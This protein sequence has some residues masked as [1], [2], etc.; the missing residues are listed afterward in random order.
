MHPLKRHSECLWLICHSRVCV[1]FSFNNI[2]WPSLKEEDY[3]AKDYVKPKKKHAAVCTPNSFQFVCLNQFEILT[4]IFTETFYLWCGVILYL[5]LHLHFLFKSH[6]QG[7]QW[8]TNLPLWHIILLY[9]HLHCCSNPKATHL[10][11]MVCGNLS[12]SALLHL[13]QICSFTVMGGSYS[14]FISVL[15]LNVITSLNND[16]PTLSLSLCLFEFQRNSI[17]LKW[18]G[19]TL[20]PSPPLPFIK[21]PLWVWAMKYELLSLAP[22]LTLCLSPLLFKSQSNSIPIYRGSYSVSNSAFYLKSHYQPDQWHAN[23]SL[24]LYPTQSPSLL[25]FIPQRNSIPI[26]WRGQFCLHLSQCVSPFCPQTAKSY[27]G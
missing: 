3:W 5:H 16:I 7:E 2:Q 4:F 25:M 22:Y 17:A 14:V 10:L 21:I 8:Q 24:T 27:N 19:P 15:C 18:G 12:Y 9:L 11:F 26:Y 1:F 6:Y 23:L 13:V 20:S